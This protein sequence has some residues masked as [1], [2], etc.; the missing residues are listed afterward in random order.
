MRDSEDWRWTSGVRWLKCGGRKESEVEALERMR[1][2]E[3]WRW[4][5]GVW[6]WEKRIGGK[7][8]GKDVVVSGGFSGH[9][10]KLGP[11]CGEDIGGSYVE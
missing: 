8:F 1:D 10:F 5:S 9:G 3:D 2:S 11:I 7:E 4:T 6:R